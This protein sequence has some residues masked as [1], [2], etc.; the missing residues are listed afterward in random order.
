MERIWNERSTAI[1]G[2]GAAVVINAL[3]QGNADMKI[4]PIKAQIGES[5][6]KNHE[7]ILVNAADKRKAAKLIVTKFGRPD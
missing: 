2:I 7:G 3:L 6:F 1:G 4:P 5:E